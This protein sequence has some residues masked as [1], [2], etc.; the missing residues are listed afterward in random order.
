VSLAMSLES[1]EAVVI[2]TANRD[3]MLELIQA[4]ATYEQALQQLTSVPWQC[5][6]LKDMYER[7]A[8]VQAVYPVW[9]NPDFQARTG[10]RLLGFYH[11]T[12]AQAG[13]ILGMPLGKMV[14]VDSDR[15]LNQHSDLFNAAYLNIGKK[16]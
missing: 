11:L 6:Y 4:C 1:L 16:Q 14:G 8:Q 3:E 7:A 12:E 13:I 2:F 5:L 15:I 9:S 10:G